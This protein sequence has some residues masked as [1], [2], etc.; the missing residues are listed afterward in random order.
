MWRK[1]K[2]KQTLL[3]YT[4]PLP[5]RSLLREWL[6]KGPPETPCRDISD[7]NVG[8][9]ESGFSTGTSDVR[10]KRIP[11]GFGYKS[12]GPLGVMG[13]WTTRRHEPSQLRTTPHTDVYQTTISP[14]SHLLRDPS[15]HRDVHTS[16]TPLTP[17]R[18]KESHLPTP[19]T[20]RI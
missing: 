1:H 16:I 20:G 6:D 8:V 13:S 12:S 19:L 15:H 14:S 2:I 7:H 18:K 10:G 4:S 9:K 3:W 11:T 5:L 17:G